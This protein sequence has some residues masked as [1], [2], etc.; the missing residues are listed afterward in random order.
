MNKKFFT[1]L[2]KD[3]LHINKDKVNK[4]VFKPNEAFSKKANKTADW[5][6]KNKKDEFVEQ[7][8]LDALEFRCNYLF[9]LIKE[10]SDENKLKSIKLL[11]NSNLSDEVEAMTT[12]YGI[13]DGKT[14]EINYIDGREEKKLYAYVS[15]DLKYKESI[16]GYWSLRSNP[17]FKFLLL[18]EKRLLGYNEFIKNYKEDIVN[19]EVNKFKNDSEIN[20]KYLNLMKKSNFKD[21]DDGEY[22]DKD[23]YEYIDNYV[24]KKLYNLSSYDGRIYDP[25]IVQ[26]IDDYFNQIG[27][28]TQ[29]LN[30]EYKLNK[31]YKAG[32]DE[33]KKN[34][35]QE[36]LE[37]MKNTKLLEC[38]KYIEIDNDVDLDKFNIFE[39]E[40]LNVMN[41]LPI[42]DEQPELR[43]RKMGNYKALGCFF[44]FN[45][46]ISID[47][48]DY[49]DVN[50]LNSKDGGISSFC[51]EYGH[52]LDYNL[53]ESDMSSKPEFSEI[54]NRYISNI[55]K[56]N[57]SSSDYEYFT[58]PTEIYARCFEV[59]LVNKGLDTPLLV[60]E[61]KLKSPQYQAIVSDESLKERLFNYFD[62]TL[63]YDM[64]KKEY[65]KEENMTKSKIDLKNCFTVQDLETGSNKL[66]RLSELDNYQIYAEDNVQIDVYID[67]VKKFHYKYENERDV[68]HFNQETKQISTG[69]GI[70]PLK[71]PDKDPDKTL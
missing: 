54:T 23:I 67:D 42:I 45:N 25:S 26:D 39:Q 70:K 58:T 8:Y 33:T 68:I 55:S 51:H 59:Y 17:D 34:I 53:E 52:F 35:N 69:K 22:S 61:E 13:T 31:S 71:G 21:L 18:N 36:T 28:F 48:R 11:D 5:F 44:P 49:D 20:E 9:Q 41:K 50:F 62:D 66:K 2:M 24:N 46:S 7:D 65:F 3:K 12:R 56:Y 40:M 60:S 4:L 64:E 57:L 29:Q 14:F 1:S 15:N 30:Y 43:L 19:S 6:Y 63:N 37:I 16:A 32:A 38:F 47:F 27:S 10:F